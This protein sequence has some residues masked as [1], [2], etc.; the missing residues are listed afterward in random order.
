MTAPVPAKTG[1]VVHLFNTLLSAA[2]Y[3]VVCD[4]DTRR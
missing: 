3:G 1:D 2:W 4:E